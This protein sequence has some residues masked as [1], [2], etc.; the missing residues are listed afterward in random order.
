MATEEKSVVQTVKD[1]LKCCDIIVINKNEELIALRDKNFPETFLN[2]LRYVIHNHNST[3]KAVS[4]FTYEM[5]L[6]VLLSKPVM[7]P[8]LNFINKVKAVYPDENS[9]MGDAFNLLN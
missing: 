1:F 6:T 3:M 9:L 2:D 7:M 5:Q 4:K 8:M